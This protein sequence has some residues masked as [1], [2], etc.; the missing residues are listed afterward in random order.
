MNKVKIKNIEIRYDDSQ[1]SYIEYIKNVISNNYDLFISSFKKIQI[2]SLVPTNEVGVMYISD[3]D[4]AFYEIVCR[5]FNNEINNNPELMLA[6]YIE[7]LIRKTN[8]NQM[9][10]VQPNPNVTD[11]ML[12][13][14]VAYI[15]FMKTGTFDDFISYLKDKKDINKIL[16][17]LQ[18]EVRFDT[19]NYLLGNTINY[20][21]Q[22]DF[23]FLDNISDIANTMLNQAMSNTLRLAKKNEIKLPS[24]TSQEFDNLFYEFLKFINAPEKWK[25]MYNEIKSSG[26]IIF[27]SQIDDIDESKCYRDEDGILKILV[28]TDGTIKYFC[29]F[30]HE[31]AHYVNMKDAVTPAPLSILEFPSIFFEKISAEFLKNK[32]YKKDIV[33]QVVKDRNKNNLHIYM[34]LSSLFYDILRFIKKGPILKADKVAFWENQFRVIQETKENIVKLWEQNYESIPDLSFL[35]QPKVDISSLVDK[36]CDTSIDNFIQNG[37]LVING[38]QYLLDTYLAEEVLKKSENDSTIISRMINVTNNLSNKNLKDILIEFDMQDLFS[39]TKESVILRK[40]DK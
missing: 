40:L 5:T 20:L 11:E 7:Y 18:A 37:L 31:F 17:W 24:I 1:N 16:D 2:I 13:S 14:L 38:Y 21:K 4:K 9:A 23:D 28:S 25:Q 32:G 35:E 34:E 26:R 30:V 36:E 6:C 12:Y 15:Y 3:F 29:S 27:K 8:S 39:Q 33:D 19:Y 22:N 10:L